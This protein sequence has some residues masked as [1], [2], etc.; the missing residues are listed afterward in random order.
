VKVAPGLG[1]MGVDGSAITTQAHR[2]HSVANATDTAWEE[3]LTAATWFAVAARRGNNPN[4]NAPLLLNG[5]PTVSP[6]SSY[7]IIDGYGTGTLR[8]QCAVGGAFFE[9]N[10]NS[11]QNN[12]LTVIVGRYTG[13]RLE[14]FY[15]GIKHATYQS[16]SGNLS[17]VNDASRGPS[18]GNF[19]DYTTTARSFNGQ[20]YLVGV[21]P[22]ALS[23]EEIA[24]LSANPWQIFAP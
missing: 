15:N 8:I 23:N 3:P 2:L 18:V 7:G 11:I 17:Y 9:I 14:G 10:I 13:S 19:Y 22:V 6:Y 24:A 12:H 1:G 5:S 21:A 16:C 4:G 20:V